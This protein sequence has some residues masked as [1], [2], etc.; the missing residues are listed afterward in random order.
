MLLQNCCLFDGE[1]M[2]DPA[3]FCFS[4]AFVMVQ[5]V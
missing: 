1:G 3:I 2:E 5:E 4:E